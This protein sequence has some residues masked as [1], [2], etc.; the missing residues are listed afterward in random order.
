MKKF[1]QRNAADYADYESSDKLKIILGRMYEGR[2]RFADVQCDL[3]AV[4]EGIHDQ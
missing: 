4:V 2:A 1:L 3:P